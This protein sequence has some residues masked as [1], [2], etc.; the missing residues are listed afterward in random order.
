MVKIEV[1]YSEYMN[2]YGDTGNIRYLQKCLD[3]VEVIYTGL[4]DEP[5][6]S[7]AKIDMIYLGPCTEN[8]QEEIIKKLLPYKDKIKE[9][10]EKDVVI[11][12]IGNALEIFGKYVEKS[13]GSRI[14]ALGIFNV[15]AK[16]E[17][18]FRYNELCLGVTKDGIEIV[19][20]KNQMSH[21]YGKD[22]EH[23]LDIFLGTGR[24]LLTNEEGIR[25][26]NFIGTYILGP[27]LLLNPFFTKAIIKKL[28][29][30]NPKLY[31]E[32]DAIKAYEVRLQEYR[33]LIKK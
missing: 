29:I 5:K 30:K 25:E 31:C 24:N 7:K 13:D 22:S 14:K 8:N 27:I 6:F 28:G 26:R 2:L 11:V 3:K 9:L 19:G 32:D 4:N 16:R 12:A 10:I 21:L 33:K 17:K 15:Y 20:F 23:F 1:L 18:D